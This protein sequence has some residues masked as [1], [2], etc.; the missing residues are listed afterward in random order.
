[1]AGVVGI[2]QGNQISLIEK[3]LPEIAYRGKSGKTLFQNG[4]CSLGM[5]WN[6]SQAPPLKSGKMK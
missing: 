6:D 1:M 2:Y 4:Y 5:I 3:L